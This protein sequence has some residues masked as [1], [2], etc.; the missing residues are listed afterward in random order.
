[1]SITVQQYRLSEFIE[2][3]DN[4]TDRDKT[5]LIRCDFEGKTHAEVGKEVRLTGARVSQLVIR[6]RRR[7]ST[8]LL[9]YMRIK[10]AFEDKEARIRLLEYKL[11][12]AEYLLVEQG[13]PIPTAE[14]V[15]ATTVEDLDVSV[16][17]YNA[18]KNHK[19]NI[20]GEIKNVGNEI[21]GWRTFGKK[22]Y[23]ELVEV[24]KSIG[25]KWPV[26]DPQL[27]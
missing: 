14:E 2:I 21:L 3:L 9:N 5:I 13:K 6:A 19:I 15:D 11:A 26:N 17:L 8:A 16:R 18:L 10:Q 22:T 20:V 23:I 25:I 1:M 12:K 24:M 4:L 7:V 27:F